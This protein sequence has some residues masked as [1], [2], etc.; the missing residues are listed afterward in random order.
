MVMW[1][2]VERMI[3]TDHAGRL[4]ALQSKITGVLAVKPQCFITHPSELVILKRLRPHE[5]RE[6]AEGNG[7]RVVRRIGGRQ[8][9]FYNDATVRPDYVLESP[10]HV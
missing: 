4:R 1:Q 8:I 9:E 10:E 3:E 2:G 7:W 6:F 5:L